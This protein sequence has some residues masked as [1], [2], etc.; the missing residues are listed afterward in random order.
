MVVPTDTERLDF[1]AQQHFTKW[2]GYDTPTIDKDLIGGTCIWPVDGDVR[3]HIDKAIEAQRAYV[4]R[5]N[6]FYLAQPL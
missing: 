5:K 2:V 6:R 4:E 1:L 3:E